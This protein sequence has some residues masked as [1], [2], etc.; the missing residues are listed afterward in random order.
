MQTL[1]HPGQ[2][3]QGVYGWVKMMG[4]FQLENLTKG[5]KTLGRAAR[6]F[7]AYGE[8]ENETHAAVA[9]VAKANL[10]MDPFEI[11]G[12]GNQ[13]RNF[14]YVGDTVRGLL[15]LGQDR[16]GPNFDVFN[17]GQ[18]THWTVNQFVEE[19]IRNSNF[20]PQRIVYNGDMPT[21][22]A[23]RA[24]DNSKMQEIFGW[25]PEVDIRTGVSR[26]SHWYQNWSRKAKTKE[27]LRTRLI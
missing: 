3:I 9:L 1:I 15:Y 22:V 21:G 10:Q 2:P 14:T 8:R 18:S 26:L 27:E 13:T 7:T 24:A 16:R 20:K 5:T 25:Q 23:S 6:I 11:W 4:E 19:V 17:V 12:S